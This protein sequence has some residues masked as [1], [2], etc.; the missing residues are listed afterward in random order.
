MAQV[1][2]TIPSATPSGQCVFYILRSSG[3]TTQR[4]SHRY[5]IRTEHIALHSASYYG[6]AQ[7]RRTYDLDLSLNFSAQFYIACAQVTVS[8]TSPP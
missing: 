5:L 3:S 4:G 2:F 1:T 7:V 8:Y 6:G